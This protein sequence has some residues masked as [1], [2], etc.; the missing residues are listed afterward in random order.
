[1]KI[2][3][4]SVV[5]DT[6]AIS[7]VQFHKD[8]WRDSGP[9]IEVYVGSAGRRLFAKGDEAVQLWAEIQVVM[10]TERTRAAEHVGMLRKAIQGMTLDAQPVGTPEEKKSC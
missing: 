6:D 8:G 2:L 4:A 7:G 5:V 3:T 10:A 9:I 1:M